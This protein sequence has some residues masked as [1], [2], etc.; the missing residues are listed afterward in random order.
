MAGTPSLMEICHYQK[1]DSCLTPLA[2]FAQLVREIIQDMA[3]SLE[4]RVQSS[5]VA[6]LQLAVE[7]FLIDLLEDANLCAVHTK[8]I[9]IVPKDI[10]LIKRLCRDK[11]TGANVELV[12]QLTGVRRRK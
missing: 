11:A 2:T 6:I 4:L 8:H 9:T 10:I 1:Q 12:A 3:P 7:A 5:A